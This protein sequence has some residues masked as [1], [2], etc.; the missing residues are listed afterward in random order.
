MTHILRVVEPASG[1]VSGL[2]P[3]RLYRLAKEGFVIRHDP[4]PVDW[5]WPIVSAPAPLRA[6]ALCRALED[7][8]AHF[9]LCSRGGYGSSD[10][11]PLLPWEKLARCPPKTL[12]G[13]SDITAL[14]SALYAQLGW[15]GIH[16]PTPGARSGWNETREP[17]LALLRGDSVEGK[18]SAQPLSGGI[19]PVTGW[20]FGG[21]L[22]VLTALLGTPYF[23]ASLEGA[24]LFLE[25]VGESPGRLMRNWNQLLQSQALRG[26]QG[27]VLGALTDIPGSLS[28]SAVKR[29][30]AHRLPGIPLYTSPD[31][32]HI[33]RNL[34]LWVGATA[35]ISSTT[36]TWKKPARTGGMR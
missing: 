11:L 18:I 10:L 17:M 21:C 32:G 33:P 35:E 27:V 36:L 12:V 6:A 23:P 14:H 22:S 20:L 1:D 4:Q 26:V 9:V 19:A 2:L 34:P 8:E 30:M 3:Q 15:T 24:I 29:E 25:D 13:F 31:F 5:N 7:P 16:G 28:A